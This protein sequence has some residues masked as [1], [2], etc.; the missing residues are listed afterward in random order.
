MSA[1]AGRSNAQTLQGIG[2]LILAVACFAVLDT[3]VKYV[4]PFVPILVAI[5]FRYLFQALAVWI[6]PDL[7][8][9]L[10][11]NLGMALL[12]GVLIAVGIITLQTQRR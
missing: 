12:G 3:S 8:V 4:G 9:R 2:L 1:A 5:W 7:G 10:P 11:T 6:S